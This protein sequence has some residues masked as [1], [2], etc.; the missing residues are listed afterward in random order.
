MQTK[1]KY[2]LKVRALFDY[3]MK[4]MDLLRSERG[5]VVDIPLFKE[6]DLP[7][8]I[9]MCRETNIDRKGYYKS[10]CNLLERHVEHGTSEDERFVHDMSEGALFYSI[11]GR[12]LEE[13]FSVF[14]DR[15]DELK[16]VYQIEVYNYFHRSIRKKVQGDDRFSLL[17][18]R[19]EFDQLSPAN[20][21]HAI[22]SQGF[23]RK[24]RASISIKERLD[25]L[26]QYNDIKAQLGASTAIETLRVENR[27]KS[28]TAVKR[29][30]RE[31]RR[32]CWNARNGIFPGLYEDS[33]IKSAI[34]FYSGGQGSTVKFFD[35]NRKDFPQEIQLLIPPQQL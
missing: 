29:V 25:L 17:F 10:I 33:K 6:D 13:K 5:V 4:S 26:H 22:T 12:L 18:T 27:Y 31:A 32:I 16:H 8:D 30:L 20:E 1:R 21:N 2:Y 14:K 15:L 7:V 3:L 9:G 24:K 11:E 28:S 19:G 34:H 35:Q 23:D